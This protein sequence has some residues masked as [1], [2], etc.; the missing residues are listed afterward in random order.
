MIVFFQINVQASTAMFMTH[1]PTR[2]YATPIP[3]ELRVIFRQV[4][5]IKPDLGLVLKAKCSHLG[6]KAPNVLATRL[7]LVAELS[8]D[9]L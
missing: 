7:K 9:L 2:H 6:L 1:N 3:N 8:K 5:M 4:Y